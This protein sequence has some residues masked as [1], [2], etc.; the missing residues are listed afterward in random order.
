MEQSFL[1]TGKHTEF[2][3]SLHELNVGVKGEAY[4]MLWVKLS[5]GMAVSVRLSVPCTWAQLRG[6][7]LSGID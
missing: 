5:G 1:T 6:G 3:C 2:V 4:T 7:T